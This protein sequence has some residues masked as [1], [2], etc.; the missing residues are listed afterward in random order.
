[1]SF[2]KLNDEYQNVWKYLYF[3]I[4]LKN[5]DSDEYTGVESYVAKCLADESLKWL[6]NKV[7]EREAQ[8]DKLRK[9]IL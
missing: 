9:R 2:S 4:Y 8:S 3:I 7:R 6:P 5:K 1:M